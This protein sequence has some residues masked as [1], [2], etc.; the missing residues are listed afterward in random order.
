M[1]CTSA[2][3]IMV[4]AAFAADEQ[5]KAFASDKPVKEKCCKKR[6]RSRQEKKEK[7]RAKE[8]AKMAQCVAERVLDSMTCRL[9]AKNPYLL[10]L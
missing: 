1:V 6:S 9:P 5:K 10:S 7:K 2:D 3:L 8:A 4:Y